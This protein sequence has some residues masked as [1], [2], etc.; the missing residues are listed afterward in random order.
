MTQKS[1]AELLILCNSYSEDALL[2]LLQRFQPLL[3]K[4]ARKFH[5]SEEYYA[6]LQ[7]HLISL[8][9]SLATSGTKWNDGQ[10]VA[11]IA[12]SIY[13]KYI[14]LSKQSVLHE[15]N[16]IEFNPEIMDH[17][18]EATHEIFLKELFQ[19]L[20]RS[21][22]EILYLHYVEGFSVQEIAKFRKTSRQSVNK[23]KNQA[24][25]ILKQYNIQK[26]N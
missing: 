23:I 18:I 24:L 26:G 9:T 20:N 21:Q 22:R 2:E 8:I 16:S 4:Y 17:P 1:F 5:D 12:K 11:Y 6:E 10:I 14:K 7:L 15:K 3:N 13:T 19:P 25:K